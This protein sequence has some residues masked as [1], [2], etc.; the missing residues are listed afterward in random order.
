MKESFAWSVDRLA[1]HLKEDAAGLTLLVKDVLD[2]TNTEAKRM[3]VGGFTGTALIVAGRQSA[4]RGRMGRSFYSPEESGLYFSIL[5]T[6]KQPLSSLVS[7]T[8]AA[9]V[10]AMR[11]IFSVCG[12]QTEIKWVND[13]Y[14]GGKKVA[15]IL[16]ESLC[17]AEEGKNSIIIGVGINLSTKMF[18]QDISRIAGS[19]GTEGDVRLLLAAEIYRALYPYLQDPESRD[20]LADYRR[21]SFVL[22]KSV[23]YTENG[24]SLT[25]VAES[26]NDDGE[27]LVRLPNKETHLLRTGEISVRL[28]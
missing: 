18:P 11:G 22:G 1:Q 13:L 21:H 6:G 27:L 19:I 10:A 17:C 25:G 26:I 24:I 5:Y 7:L 12:V 23:T 14:L 16:C 2:S 8:G 20:W 28:T 4:G 3:A 9:A 15:G